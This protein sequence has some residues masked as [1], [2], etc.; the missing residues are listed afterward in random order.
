MTPFGEKM[1]DLRDTKGVSQKQMAQ[2]LGVSGAYLSA[3]EHGNRGRPAPGMIMQICDYFGLIWDD[4]EELK[5]LARMSHPRVT[6]DTAGLSARATELA[7]ELA[8]SIGD[9]DEQTLQWI[10][11]EIRAQKENKSSG[12]VY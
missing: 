12:P 8:D 4:S 9:L 3:L 1:R 10:L 7:N 2:A 5:R 11:D 6:V